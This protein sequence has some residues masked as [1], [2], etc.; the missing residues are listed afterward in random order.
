VVQRA[1]GQVQSLRSR[2]LQ[3]T[4]AT[5]VDSAVEL[6]LRQGYENTT[7]QQITEAADISPRTFNRYFANKDEVFIAVL[8]DLADEIASGMSTQPPDVGPLEAGRAA[9]VAVLTRADSQAIDGLTADRIRL[10]LRIVTVSDKLQRA[11][12][13]YRNPRSMAVLASR[14]GVSA[15][16]PR[17]DLVTALFI[18]TVVGACSDL[19]AHTD[20]AALRPL[21]IAEHID[22]AFGYVAKYAADLTVPRDG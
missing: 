5:L 16:D 1:D 4:R 7:I 11:T 21:A 20:S 12:L 6:C 15:D 13:E 17:V 10:I 18:L 9:I 3:R 19:V 14:M 22:R 2:K 8:D